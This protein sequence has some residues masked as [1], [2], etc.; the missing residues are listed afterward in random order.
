MYDILEGCLIAVE[1][2][3]SMGMQTGD[4]TY[5]LLHLSEA[6][7]VCFKAFADTLCFSIQV[8]E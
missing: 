6:V 7:P 5:V 4:S 8:L 1:I 2:D 3:V